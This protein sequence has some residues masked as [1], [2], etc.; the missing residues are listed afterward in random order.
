MNRYTRNAFVFI[1]TFFIVVLIFR[2]LLP[3]S[4][5]VAEQEQADY[6]GELVLVEAEAEALVIELF[7][8][9]PP[10]MNYHAEVTYQTT[11]SSFFC[12]DFNLGSLIPFGFGSGGRDPEFKEFVYHAK[13]QYT[14]HHLKIPLDEYKSSAC[15]WVPIGVDVCLTQDGYPSKS[16]LK[17]FERSPD[18]ESADGKILEIEC[19]PFNSN[20]IAYYATACYPADK[21]ANE[22]GGQQYN[23]SKKRHNFSYSYPLVSQRIETN[24]S[25]IT[26]KQANQR[27]RAKYSRP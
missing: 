14:I 25:M 13:I 5:E 10:D 16:C 21:K 9:I 15:N 1:G 6:S 19:V 23:Y 3:T 11:S 2:S 17:L 24:F 12:T 8:E 26:V 4:I 27:R 22:S 20:E 18:F 7:G